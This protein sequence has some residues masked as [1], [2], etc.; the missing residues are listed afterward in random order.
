MQKWSHY[1]LCHFP[2]RVQLMPPL[3]ANVYQR[4]GR[5]FSW[6]AIYRHPQ[7]STQVDQEVEGGMKSVN[8]WSENCTLHVSFTWKVNL[9]NANAAWEL[10]QQYR[11]PS[12]SFL[13]LGGCNNTLDDGFVG[14]SMASPWIPKFVLFIW[15]NY[16]RGNALV[17]CWMKCFRLLAGALPGRRIKGN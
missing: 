14:R 8:Q 12:L 17:S 7:P 2:L 6:T 15:G 10:G 13:V 1:S 5:E 3:Y 16:R 4:F 11:S 9:V